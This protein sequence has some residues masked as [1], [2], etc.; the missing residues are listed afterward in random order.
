MILIIDKIVIF[1]LLPETVRYHL[2]NLLALC[3]QN[4]FLSIFHIINLIRY[5]RAFKEVPHFK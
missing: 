1:P 4:H 5:E 2:Q 3:D